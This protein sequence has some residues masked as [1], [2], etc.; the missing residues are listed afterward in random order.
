MMRKLILLL[1][2][3]VFVAVSAHAASLTV[4]PSSVTIM[5]STIF[6][7]EFVV[8]D[9]TAADTVNLEM[10][11]DPLLVEAYDAVEGTWW[12]QASGIE[13]EYK[14][15]GGGIVSYTYVEIGAIMTGSGTIVR[16][17]FHC[18]DPGLAVI[19]YDFTLV[20][21]GSPVIEQTG[22]IQAH[23]IPEPVTLCLV[24]GAL[25]ALAV[26]ARKRS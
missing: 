4:E 14:Q 22:T 9:V 18:E 24:G 8:H 25:T 17:T 12:D 3:A 15:V 5:P 16:V 6:V 23:Q 11:Y 20:Y 7:I 10:S 13:I 21:A 26:I 2:L 1:G 19:P